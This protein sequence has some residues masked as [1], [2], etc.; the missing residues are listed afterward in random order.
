MSSSRRSLNAISLTAIF[1]AAAFGVIAGLSEAHSP[2]SAAPMM[3]AEDPS[4]CGVTG[5][6]GVAPTHARVCDTIDVTLAVSATCP[7]RPM[8]IVL[9]VD[10]SL[11]TWCFQT[12]FLASAKRVVDSFERLDVPVKMG[13]VIGRNPRSSAAVELTDDL[14]DVSR[15]I[16]MVRILPTGMN[17]LAEHLMIEEGMAM[18]ERGRTGEGGVEAIVLLADSLPWANG[19]AP[20]TGRSL[21]AARRARSDGIEVGI[22]CHDTLDPACRWAAG[23][24]Q[25]S[26]VDLPKMA[27]R[28][29]LYVYAGDGLGS[30]GG[31]AESI[32]RSA[33]DLFVE[34]LLI[35]GYRRPGLRARSGFDVAG[36]RA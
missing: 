20:E 13:L 16:N 2:R 12:R 22:S 23:A 32:A 18:L 34:Q 17:T 35:N 5:T 21:A 24:N 31:M 4:T 33:S 25:C 27:S 15:G 29:S 11:A 36:R 7:A 6:Y 8:H 30:Y 3:V 1:L 19:L 9:G 10:E 26:E 28:P 14:D